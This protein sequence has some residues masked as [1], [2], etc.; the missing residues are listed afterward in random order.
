METS[1]IIILVVIFVMG[2]ILGLILAIFKPLRKEEEVIEE[3][4]PHIS[5]LT[6]KDR[7]EAQAILDREDAETQALAKQAKELGL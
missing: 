6:N 2:V 3:V 7:D 4:L 1:Q 5:F